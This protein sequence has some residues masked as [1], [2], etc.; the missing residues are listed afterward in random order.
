MENTV[1]QG[2]ETN[3]TP[4]GGA[5]VKTFTQAELDAIVSDRLKR[6]RAKYEGFEDLKAKAAKFDEI[7]EANKTELQKATERAQALENELNGMKKAESIRE[8]REKVAKEK[9]VPAELLHGDDEEACN[10]EADNLLKFVN[11]SG[12]Y[13]N[14]K[15][16]GEVT[17]TNGS[18]PRDAFAQFATAMND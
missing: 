16:G 2:N 3:N 6:E 14:V 8:L 15:D 5:E 1:N 12:G 13:P 18:S 17:N 10:V 7:E 11:N 4:N 9:G